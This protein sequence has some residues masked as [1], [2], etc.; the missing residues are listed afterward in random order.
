MASVSSMTERSRD[1]GAPIEMIGDSIDHILELQNIQLTFGALVVMEDVSLSVARGEVCS[2]IGPNGAGKSSLLNVI[3]GV[4][5]AKKGRVIVDGHYLK[6]PTPQAVA[7]LS[8]S[9]TF[10]HN[11]LFAKMSVRD[12]IL[13]GLTRLLKG[14]FLEQTFRIGRTPK[15]NLWANEK[16]DEILEYLDLTAY[17][18]IPVGTLPYGFQKRVDLGRS[19]ISAPK[20]LLLDEPLAGMNHDEKQEMGERISDVN[21]NRN[22]TIVLIEHDMGIVMNISDHIVV[23]NYGEKIADD[24][25]SEVRN[26]PA[27]IKAYLGEEE[28]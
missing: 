8:T 25:P 9:R 4:Y 12:N 16:L 27:V 7:K 3:N 15:E 17:A 23:L 26:D 21:R 28:V 1:R 19:L 24:T 11:A 14:N 2:I 22:A 5:P 6:K 18:D 13:T 20:L 10:Q